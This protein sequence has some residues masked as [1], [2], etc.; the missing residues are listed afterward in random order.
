MT[1][2]KAVCLRCYT[3]DL[4]GPVGK[5]EAERAATGHMNA[6]HH[7]VTILPVPKRPQP[8]RTL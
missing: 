1:R 6:Y 4:T 2:Y 8:A 3:Y 5:R 7:D